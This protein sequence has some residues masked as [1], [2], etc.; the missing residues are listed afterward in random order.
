M[1]VSRTPIK[2]EI[3]AFKIAAGTLPRAMETMTTE[4]ETVEGKAAR[5]KKDSQK[6]DW[7][8]VTIKG[9]NAKMSSGNRRKVVAWTKRCKRQFFNPDPISAKLSFNP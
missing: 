6:S 8:A 9:L 7:L 5:K 3:L 4:E 2:P 1:G